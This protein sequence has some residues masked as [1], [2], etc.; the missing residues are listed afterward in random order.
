MRNDVSGWQAR[1]AIGILGTA[2]GKDV[3]VVNRGR[4]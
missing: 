3:N 1:R 2:L 4:V